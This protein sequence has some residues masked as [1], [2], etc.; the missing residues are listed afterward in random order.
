MSNSLGPPWTVAHQAPPSMGFSRQEYWSGLPFLQGIF[1]TQSSKLG[2]PHCRQML[3][4]LSHQVIRSFI[5]RGTVVENPPANAG[6][7][8]SIP[9]SGRSP[10]GG[11]SNPVF[12]PEK[13]PWTKEPGGLQLTGSQR[14]GH[15]WATEH[16]CKEEVSDLSLGEVGA[17]SSAAIVRKR[18]NASEESPGLAVTL[19]TSAFFLGQLGWRTQWDLLL[20]SHLI[21]SSQVL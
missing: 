18:G 16:A 3:L 19:E 1:V 8:G 20:Q 13:I 6:D 9:G 11:N 17:S 15:N 21:E 10:G 7:M 14:V 12:L 2:L 4:P 5:L